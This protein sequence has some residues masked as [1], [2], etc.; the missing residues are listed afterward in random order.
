MIARVSAVKQRDV[1]SELAAARSAGDDTLTLVDPGELDWE[2]G[3]LEIGAET[4][5]YTVEEDGTIDLATPLANAYAIETPV[6]QSPRSPERT[7]FLIEE[8]QIEEVAA[9]VPHGLHDRLP[10]GV[11][12]DPA[13]AEAVEAEFRDGEMV[14]I[15]VFARRPTIDSAFVDAAYNESAVV[16][17]LD[18]LGV[19]YTALDGEVTITR[20]EDCICIVEWG[21][22]LEIYN[23]GGGHTVDGEAWASL[24]VD[25]GSGAGY[26]QVGVERFALVSAKL[27]PTGP[28]PEFVFPAAGGTFVPMLAGVEY[29]IAIGARAAMTNGD[30]RVPALKSGGFQY[31]FFGG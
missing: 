2:G 23:F 31:A 29:T 5:A 9:R 8:D 11:R 13:T 3:T 4:I 18:P 16:I 6:Y 24:L 15:D 1:G 28:A 12:L 30:A 17:G 21:C 22:S 20:D 7:V 26:V 19:D 25:D 14:A 27:D 10:T